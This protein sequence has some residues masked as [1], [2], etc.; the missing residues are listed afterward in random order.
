MSEFACSICKISSEFHD[1][2]S[3]H[4]YNGQ[5]EVCEYGNQDAFKQ[6]QAQRQ[7]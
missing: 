2:V 3:F 5:V 7:L 6:L 1:G 4:L